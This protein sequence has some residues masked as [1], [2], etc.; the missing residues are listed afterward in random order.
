MGPINDYGQT[1]EAND[2]AKLSNLIASVEAEGVHLVYLAS[3]RD[4]FGNPG[5]YAAEVFQAWKLSD[6]HL[7]LVFVRSE[8]RKWR[9]A[10]HSGAALSLP[11]EVEELRSKAEREANRIRPGSAALHFVSSLLS[12]VREGEARPKA[13]GS[14]PW[15]YVLFAGLFVFFVV[16]VGLRICPRCGRPLRRVRSVS[17]II[18]VCPRCRYTRTSL[19]RGRRPGGRRGFS[20]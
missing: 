16:F 5:R 14:F 10:I 7:L 15:R 3:W 20:P 8:D 1:L 9:V 17:G 13:A 18:W 12:L 6:K 4:P 2:R 11:R 19:G